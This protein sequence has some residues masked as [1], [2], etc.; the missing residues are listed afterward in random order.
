MEQLGA[1]GSLFRDDTRPHAQAQSASN[2]HPSS[3][4]GAPAEAV[5]MMGTLVAF[6]SPALSDPQRHPDYQSTPAS[7]FYQAQLA[8]P[9]SVLHMAACPDGARP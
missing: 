2:L 8:A 6:P 1:W 9:G 7:G 3:V 4:P 5:M